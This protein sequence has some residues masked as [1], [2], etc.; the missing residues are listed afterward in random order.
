MLDFLK[1]PCEEEGEEVLED[2]SN[3]TEE[4]RE[5]ILLADKLREYGIGNE[6]DLEE[7]REFML[8]KAAQRRA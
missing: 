6:A 2:D 4:Q 1:I 3:L 8:R 5:K 7:F